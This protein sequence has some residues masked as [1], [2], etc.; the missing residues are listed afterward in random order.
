M[1]YY[2]ANFNNNHR[3]INLLNYIGYKKNKTFVHDHIHITVRED[4]TIP[5]W[6]RNRVKSIDTVIKEHFQTKEKRTRSELKSIINMLLS[7]DMDSKILG[8]TLLHNS[9]FSILFDSQFIHGAYVRFLEMMCFSSY[10]ET[11]IKNQ[12]FE[13][14]DPFLILIRKLLNE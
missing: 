13:Q 5:Y 1:I 8:I 2:N 7:E 6:K 3:Y 10:Y 4:K 14:G 12:I 11:I 9:D